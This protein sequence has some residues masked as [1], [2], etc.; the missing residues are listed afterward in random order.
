[1]SDPLA[2][3]RGR[4]PYDAL[5][6]R[7]VPG[8]VR[9]TPRSRQLAIQLRKRFPLELGPALGVSEFVMAKAVACFLIARLRGDG[10]SPD[11]P[12]FERYLLD[13]QAPD[14]GWGYEFDVQ[15]R[16]A[17]YPAGASNTIATVF[18]ARALATAVA[19]GSGHL[20]AREAL[21]GA[22]E[23]LGGPLVAASESGAYVRYT[24][25]SDALVHNANLLACGVLA[26]LGRLFSD[27]RMIDTALGCART[28][29]EAQRSDGSWPYGDA[30]S[31]GWS[32][33]F[34]TAYN[35]DGL[36]MVWLATGDEAVR[37]SLEAGAEHWV[38]DF[39]GEDGEPRYYVERALPYDIHSAG[40]AIDV[41]AR[42]A[43][44]G[45][46]T[47]QVAW[48]VAEWTDAHLVD[49]RTGATYYRKHR[50]W[51]DRRHFVRWGDAHLA[52]GRASLALLDTGGRDPLEQAV[53]RG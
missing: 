49:H 1:M 3:L 17:F 2:G 48:R 53:H 32:D 19:A 28:S 22:A 30:A 36:L 11:V 50:I 51:T 18:A 47:E 25:T 12:V 8:F 45:L 41:A 24:G 26:A 46:P 15:T 23:L 21:E 27:V 4:D 39:F 5:L 52:M 38:R 7:R 34:H 14:G 33:N 20:A 31:L 40:T 9:R 37:R 6:G 43:T 42:L 13:A 44:W 35:L 10:A 29:I 16:W